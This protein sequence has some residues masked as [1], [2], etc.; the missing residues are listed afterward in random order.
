[1]KMLFPGRLSVDY[2]FKI[3]RIRTDALKI[4]LHDARLYALEAL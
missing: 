2:S 4:Y 3:S 1:M